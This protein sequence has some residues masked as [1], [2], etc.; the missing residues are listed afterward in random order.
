LLPW[1]FLS[2]ARGIA[3]YPARKK[4]ANIGWGSGLIISGLGETPSLKKIARGWM[5]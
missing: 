1:F 3:E 2:N 5:T 4:R